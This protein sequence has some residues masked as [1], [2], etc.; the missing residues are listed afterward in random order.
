MLE[1][2]FKFV[3]CPY[4]CESASEFSI[5][6]VAHATKNTEFAHFQ[7]KYYTLLRCQSE[8]GVFHCQCVLKIKNVLIWS[9]SGGG[10]GVNIFEVILKL[11]KFL[12][13]Q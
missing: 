10:G 7:W 9:E 13:I 1:S 4:V 11:K 12:I 8:R 5:H 6:I 3:M 2:P